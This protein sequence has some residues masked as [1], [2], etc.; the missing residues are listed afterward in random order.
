MDNS[1]KI[2]GEIEITRYDNG[3]FDGYWRFYNLITNVGF[4]YIRRLL[5]NDKTGGINKL[6][7]G[8]DSTA[9]SV[10]DTKLKNE[11]IRVNFNNK[12]Y[13]IDKK[14]KFLAVIPEN[15][16]QTSVYYKEAGLYYDTP[17]EKILVSRLVFQSPIFQSSTKSL[18]ISYNISLS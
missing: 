16:F 3:K 2:L 11:I 7:L 6:A 13:S 12:D 8:D 17:T 9:A 4:D 14:V 5:G 10:N 15:T 1:L 18:S